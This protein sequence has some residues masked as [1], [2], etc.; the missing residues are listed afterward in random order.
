MS[1]LVWDQ[2]GQRF[3]ESGVSRGV[4]F[5]MSDNAPVN[6]FASYNTGVA[7][8]GL[9]GVDESPD[10]A[11][12]QVLWADNLK[13]AVFRTPENHKG[14]I[15]AYTYPPEWR[16]CD[17]QISMGDPATSGIFVGLQK[18]RPFA[19]A[20]R[21]EVNNDTGTAADDGYIIHVVYNCTVSPSSKSRTTQNENPDAVE[22]NW[23][24]SATPVVLDSAINDEIKQV[25]VIEFDSRKMTT[26]QKTALENALYGTENANPTLP[27][28]PAQFLSAINNAT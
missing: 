27:A 7:W 12:E 21:T 6:G 5:V 4:L 25:T 20:Y 3:Y 26:A 9:T 17:G 13:Y 2:A 15:K 18:R 14:T 19:F 8:N 22:F 10:G 11:D 28:D 1:K 24:Y 23:D 16:A